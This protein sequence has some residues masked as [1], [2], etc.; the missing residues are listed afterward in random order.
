MI[1]RWGRREDDSKEETPKRHHGR[2][3]V[4]FSNDDLGT[5]QL[6]HEDPVIISTVIAHCHVQRILVDNGSS[7]DVLMYDALVRMGLVLSQLRRST[8]P[9]TGFGGSQVRAEGEI[10]LPV[11]LRMEL[12]REPSQ[13]T[14]L[15][16]EFPRP[17]TP[18]LASQF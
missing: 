2:N 3:A 5:I 18:Y 12:H 14:L 13:S 17:I 9:L 11:T 7:T 16:S 10:T 15:S 1:H 8:T 6:P 4:S